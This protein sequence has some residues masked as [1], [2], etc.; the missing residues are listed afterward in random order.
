MP[1]GYLDENIKYKA[2]KNFAK[3]VHLI[4]DKDSRVH[5]VFK[6]IQNHVYQFSLTKQDPF[7]S[8][9]DRVAFRIHMLIRYNK[10]ITIGKKIK[11]PIDISLI[12]NSIE[13]EDYDAWFISELGGIKSIAKTYNLKIIKV[14]KNQLNFNITLEAPIEIFEGSSFL[15]IFKKGKTIK[16]PETQYERVLNEAIFAKIEEL[17]PFFQALLALYIERA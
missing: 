1:K 8:E 17:K 16:V 7:I 14:N 5:T 2:I 3:G 15:G 6:K 13:G 4:F 11:I 9:P 12:H 10:R